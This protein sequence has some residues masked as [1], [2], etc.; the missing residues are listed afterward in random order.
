MQPSLFGDDTPA[1]VAPSG[2]SLMFE[3]HETTGRRAK[4][5]VTVKVSGGGMSNCFRLP[6]GQD[7]GRAAREQFPRAALYD[8]FTVTILT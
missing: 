1:R 2:Q 4:G 6:V 3:E 8:D 7:P 5:E